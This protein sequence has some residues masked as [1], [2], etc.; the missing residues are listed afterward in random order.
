MSRITKSIK[1]VFNYIDY[2]IRFDLPDDTLIKPLQLCP[3]VPHLDFK[4]QQTERSFRQMGCALPQNL[5]LL[6]FS[7]SQQ[8]QGI[9]SYL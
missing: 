2:L 5:V 3:E 9:S 6:Q 4:V 8:S 1:L 7:V